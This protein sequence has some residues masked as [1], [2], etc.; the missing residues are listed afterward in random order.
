MSQGRKK[1]RGKEK[2]GGMDRLRER[3]CWRNSWGEKATLLDLIP[4]P[5]PC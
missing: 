1:G 3:N 2:G 4:W 5:I